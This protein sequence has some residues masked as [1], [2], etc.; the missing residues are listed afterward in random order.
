MRRDLL[1]CFNM[2]AIAAFFVIL[3]SLFF[4]LDASAQLPV[5]GLR[6]NG[7]LV[8][9][10]DTITICIGSSITYTSTSQFFNSL[11]WR[12]KNG[13]PSTG[14]STFQNVFYNVA[15]ID[16]TWHTATSTSGADSIFIFVKVNTVKP[17]PDFS[18]APNNECG[19]IPIVFTNA[20]SGNGLTYA[21]NFGDGGTSTTTN[22][23]YQFLNAIGTSGIVSYT[24]KLVV[25]NDLFCKDSIN[26]IVTVKRIPDASIASSIPGVTFNPVTG[27]FRRCENT[28]SF[29]FQFANTSTTTGIITQY[30]I[31]WGDTSPDSVF[32]TWA[33]GAIIKHPY[34]IG[35]HDLT[36]TVN[37]NNGCIGIKKYKVFLGTNP[38][39]G[40][41]SPGN[42]SICAPN[43]LNFILSGFSNNTPGTT[44]TISVN[45][46]SGFVSFVHPPPDTITH[47]FT[48]GSCGSSSS[49][50]SQT[51]NNAFSATLNIENPCNITSVSVIPIYVSGKPRANFTVS[52]SYNVCTNSNI[53]ISNFSLYGGTI[54][55]SG[56]GNSICSNIGRQVWSISPSTGFTLNS[57]I[58]GSLNNAPTNALLWTSGTGSLNVNFNTPGI[59]TVKLY[60]ANDLCGMDSITKTICVRLPPQASFTMNKRSACGGDTVLLNNTSPVGS[61]LGETYSWSVAYS[62]PL[63]CGV[64]TSPAFTYVNGTSSISKNPAIRFVN[65]GRYIITLSVN[66]TGTQFTCPVA[67]FNDTFYVKGRPKVTVNPISSICIANSISPTA[68]V[69]NCYA[70]SAAIYAWTFTNG[71]PATHGFAVPPPVSFSAIGLHPV[72]LSVTNEC[73]VTTIN[74]TAN[75]TSIPDAK[76]GRDTSICS[77]VPVQVGAAPIPG[78]A[79]SWLP[80]SG[81]SSTVTANPT[82]TINYNGP[83]ADTTITYIVTVSAGTNCTNKD[84]VNIIVKKRPVIIVTPSSAL[85]C[86][87]ASTQL[88]AGGAQSYSWLPVAG[89]NNPLSDTIVASPATTTTYTVIGIAANGCSAN[90]NATVTVV[91]FLNTSAGRDTLVCNSSTA[92]Q[93][94]GTPAGGTWSGSN[95]TVGGLFNPNAAGNGT[96]TLYYTAGNNNCNRTDSMLVTV[97]DIPVADAGRDTTVC[98]S[99]TSFQLAGMPAGGRWSGSPSVT[100]G[101]IFTPSTPGIYSL[102]YTIGG[103]SCV[104]SD[105]VLIT[106]GAGISNNLI[107]ADQTICIGGTPSIISGQ[108]VTGGNGTPAYQWQSSNNNILWTN[109]AGATGKDYQPPALSDT[110]WYRRIAT[111]TLCAGAQANMS[112]AI[113]IL[114]NPDAIAAFNPTV[115]KGCIPFNITP[116]I[117]NLSLYNDRVVEYKWYVNGNYIGSGQ[118]FPGYTMNAAGDSITVKL[119]AVSRFGCKNDSTQRGFVTVETPV[120]T[121]TQSN[122]IGCGPLTINFN[123]TTANAPRYNFIWNFGQGQQSTLAQPGPIVFPINPLFGDTTYTITL[124]AISA[125]DTVTA[126]STVTVRA[127]PRVV[128]TPG[129]TNGCSPMRVTFIN[130]SQ[131]S[132][133][134]YSWD[135]GDGSPLLITNST[136]VQHTFTTGV[137]DT[138]YVKL[139]GTNDCGSDSMI[140]N[141]VVNPN[142]IQLDFAVNGNERFGCAPHTVNFVNNTIGANSFTWNF[143]DGTIITTGPT[144]GVF[145]HTYTIAGTF[146]VSL[147]ATNSCNDTI[148]YEPITVQLKP[149][150]SFVASPL[151]ACVRD[152]IFFTNTSSTGITNAWSFGN[153]TASQIRNPF[154]TYNAPGT[155]RVRLI[156]SNNFPQGL[157]CSDSAF[158]NILIRDTLPGAFT[159]SNNTGV[160]LPFV[161]TFK[162]SNQPS[163]FTS[164][165]F[166]DGNTATG[167]S[168]THTYNTQG[169]FT[170]TM[171]SKPASGGCTYKSAQV[172]NVTSPAGTLIYNGGYVCLGTP[173]RL[174]VRAT[175]AAQ[176]RFVFGDG[177][178]I[179]TSSSIIFHTYSRPG[180]FVPHAYLLAGNCAIK[181]ATGDTIKVDQVKAGFNQTI[182]K[183]CGFTTVQFTDTSRAYF[184][185][186]GR[187]WDFGDGTNSGL[188][189]PTHF[190]TQSGIYNI[191]LR[192]RGVS[193][194]FDT[195]TVPLSIGVNNYPDANIG[196]DTIACSGQ[197]VNLSALINSSDSILNYNWNFGNTVTGSGKNVTTIY[198][199]TGNYTIRLI[200]TT[201]NGCADTAFKLIRVNASPVVT[202]GADVRICKGKS[203]QLRAAGATS[204]QWAPLQDLSCA[205]CPNPIANPSMS[206]QYVVSG[207]NNFQCT[208]TDTISVEVIQPFVMTLSAND[209]I[210]VGQQTQLF[211][212]GASTYL[213][214]PIVGLSSGTVAN[215]IARPIVSTQ[216]TVI[217]R[218]TYNCFADTLSVIIIVGE[219]PV[220]DLGSGSTVIAGT[221]IPFNPV[222]TNGPFKRYV[223]TPAI[224]LSCTNCANPVATINN[225]ITYKL[226]AENIYG[227]KGSDTIIYKIRCEEE[228]QVYIPNAFSP[229]GDGVNDLFMVRGKGLASIKY[230]RVFNRW[231]QL[232]FERSNFMANDSKNAWDGRVNGIPATPDV[233]VFTAEMTCT[234]GDVYIKKGNLT[235]MR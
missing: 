171:I 160:C 158:A 65:G 102:T 133:V 200:A 191:R 58:Y 21:W 109:I 143:G 69:S 70:D 12:F 89:I 27:V 9:R 230:F 84:T 219:Y 46:G 162:N 79:Y 104:G 57:G 195:I 82:A 222:L 7:K 233:Y 15:G 184:G 165:N 137:R 40:F 189:N 197:T 77:G 19:N 129:R 100:V 90:S 62:D 226:E 26:K 153:N 139:K 38:A 157:S 41:A 183:S 61:C 218:D 91:P 141:I 213:W 29:L 20:S 217:G 8:N 66:A 85:I 103:G 152:T 31:K 45:D 192:I 32:T 11:A 131:G 63:L 67:I 112:N 193:N 24:V 216:Y 118:S 145:S 124:K 194:C 196:G 123:N 188:Q 202:A 80:A 125:C 110:I 75:V 175:N 119:V 115:V 181:I 113:R 98:Q 146:N 155:Y 55:P 149:A 54:V 88:V 134:N 49:N 10:G 92:I 22:P 51:F 128:F 176:Y 172:I 111:T 151:V 94:T 169:S 231:G 18:F 42:T 47:L 59:Y 208:S 214:N 199:V 28:P 185:I 25:T 53:N 71:T 209:T 72:T 74:T 68:V 168:V 166:G 95:V 101:G 229:D 107:S 170:V 234:G 177:D 5:A 220:V 182:T 126:T 174:E 117:I 167:D 156:G 116:A 13:S 211:A 87:G 86:A 148:D 187:V 140:F 108:I 3:F 50:G 121:F 180:V 81:L 198:N 164:W 224:D 227:C 60:I 4:A 97:I 178:S 232:I 48:T 73:G 105:A 127:K 206:T 210:C 225:N 144:T 147:Y 1:R 132:N 201:N 78:Y 39:G 204:W 114:V 76:A 6:A 16:S 35:Q 205:T 163:A 33:P 130:S 154:V 215:P 56:G 135:F 203:V 17:T 64:N 52:P 159:V 228:S 138:F 44:Y 23:S 83:G 99:N 207:T 190:Y 161:V 136:A 34:A 173:V 2:A 186:A 120:T 93:L 150:V 179:T 106:V 142:S 36:I 43:A 96:Y 235:L 223:W 37:G 212:S 221:M 122:T 14:S 30:T